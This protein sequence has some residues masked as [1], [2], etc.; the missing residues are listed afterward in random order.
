MNVNPQAKKPINDW[1]LEQTG[2][3][4]QSG[5]FAG[6]KLGAERCW[7]DGNLGCE[8]L[9]CYEAELHPAIE[10]EI[11][12]L[13]RLKAP[14]VVNVGCAEGYYAVGIARRVP[15]A[16]M[17]A[18][19]ISEAAFEVMMKSAAENGVADRIVVKESLAIV[20]A[21]PELVVMDCEG[22]ETEYLDFANYPALT[23]SSIIVECHDAEKLPITKTLTERF[24]DTHTIRNV[25]EGARDP[26]QFPMMHKLHSL[27]RW[28]AVSEGRPCL[29][30][31][32]IMSPFQ[33]RMVR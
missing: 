29:M 26:N 21:E 5:P 3:I 30:N 11:I 6:M 17:Y 8:L 22:W 23:N 13:N 16:T 2:G 14:K 1:L 4:V 19:D 31:W 25:V 7:D 32:L 9:G 28:A 15:Q 33:P 10:R 18:V 24:A 20:F 12:R 27:D